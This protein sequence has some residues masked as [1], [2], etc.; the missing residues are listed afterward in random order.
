MANEWRR[1]GLGPRASVAILARNHRGFLEAVYAAGKCG[2]SVVL[3]NTGFGSVQLADM[4][5]RE[6]V[7]LLVHDDEFSTVVA[8]VRPRLG[9]IRAWT[10]TPQTP[11]VDTLDAL[12]EHGDTAPPPRCRALG[13]VLADTNRRPARQ[14][15]VS[16][17]RSHRM[18]C[19]AVSFAGF[20]PRDVR[21]GAGL[22][23]GVTP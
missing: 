1:L 14:G 8:D 10:D 17:P 16:R 18:L 20:Q 2:A 19:A 11:G 3:F 9:R 4:V 22:D 7:D 21:D 5:T 12:I 6:R 15:A 23:A 13:A